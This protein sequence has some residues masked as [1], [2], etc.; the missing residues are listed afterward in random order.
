MVTTEGGDVNDAHEYFPD[1]AAWIDSGKAKSVDGF[2]F[3]G[4]P[5]DADTGFYDFGQRFYDPRL[6]LWLGVDSAFKGTASSAV[7]RPF[8]LSTLSFS[9]Q[10]PLHFVDKDGRDVSLEEQANGVCYADTTCKGGSVDW[11]G[12]AEWVKDETGEHE[13][14]ERLSGVNEWTGWAEEEVAVQKAA[15]SRPRLADQGRSPTDYFRRNKEDAEDELNHPWWQKLGKGLVI[16]ATVAVPILAEADAAEVGAFATQESTADVAIGA[17]S[18]DDLSRAAGAAD[19]GGLTAAGR[20]LQK[21]GG[22]PGSAFPAAR[23][24]PA[25]INQAGQGIVDDILANP[26][27]TTTTRHHARFGDVIEIRAPD[28]RGVRYDANGRFIGLLEP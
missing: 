11:Y 25:Q 17:S 6:S 16:A 15:V 23:G 28:G 1:G 2:L 21:H 3:S 10:N 22:R 5:F 4:K 24:N 18:L 12:H 9:A 7:S 26:G 14:V 8:V 13:H 20:A 19:R 27:S